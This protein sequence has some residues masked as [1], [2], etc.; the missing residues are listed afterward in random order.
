LTPAPTSCTFLLVDW[1][2]LVGRLALAQAKAFR[3]SGKYIQSPPALVAPAVAAELGAQD[4]VG[5]VGLRRVQQLAPD[6]PRHQ[7]G[8]LQPGRV[9]PLVAHHRRE[10]E[11]LA[12]GV[13]RADLRER[14]LQ[15][16]VLL[17]PPP[18]EER[19]GGS[20]AAAPVFQLQVHTLQPEAHRH[21]VRVRRL[22]VARAVLQL[23]DGAGHQCELGAGHQRVQVGEERVAPV[24]VA[25]QREGGAV[26]PD[27]GLVQ[28][29]LLVA[30]V[31]E[32]E[33]RHG[34]HGPAP[35]TPPSRSCRTPARTSGS[36][37][38]SS[39]SRGRRFRPRTRCNR[40]SRAWA[41]VPERFV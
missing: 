6:R 2:D 11:H 10:R 9:A 13:A 22:G 16:P 4:V 32:L 18:L 19:V 37:G 5:P 24:G 29:H 26:L 39:P 20:P 15:F 28:D 41:V 8:Q 40:R 34:R 21:V 17:R 25:Q 12:G 31:P 33:A 36:W 38:R 1:A 35:R 7:V 23:A 14:R 27:V 30:E 3:F